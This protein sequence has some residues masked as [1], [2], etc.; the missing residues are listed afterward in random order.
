[1]NDDE[2]TARLGEIRK[3]R[4]DLL[5]RKVD[6]QN[7]GIAE[8]EDE[9]RKLG[10][11]EGEI[12]LALFERSVR[13]FERQPWVKKETALERTKEQA[14]AYRDMFNG[15]Y[16][17]VLEARNERLEVTHSEWPK[18]PPI[19][20]FGVD[21]LRAPL[22]DAYSA[23]I[24]GALSTRLDLMDARGQV[25]DAWRQIAVT[26][27]A[28]QGVLNVGYNYSVTGT[29]AKYLGYSPATAQNQLVVN[30]QLP[31]VRRAQRNA[32]RSALINYQ[33]TRRLLMAF[34]DNIANDVRND[35]RQ[36]RALA[37]V[38][39]IQQRVVEQS[40]SIV[41][42]AAE[43]LFAPPVPG[44]VLDPG[45]AASLTNQLLTA[46]SNLLTA[47]NTLYVYW[48]GFIQNRIQLYLDLELMQLDE[49]GIW[50]DEQF[51]GLED[52]PAGPDGRPAGERLPAPL[53]VVP[54]G[55]AALGEPGPGGRR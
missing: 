10:Q 55:P 32:Y 26:A 21:A 25:V 8:P 13:A 27:N 50:R 52:A 2:I 38:Y 47:Q 6:R 36:L 16:Q 3:Q 41:E 22:D 18:L 30:A 7:K 11:L 40:Y 28:L 14:S 9:V 44:T 39:K 53:P 5:D 31:L 46:L 37:E 45:T 1:L 43:V 35:I 20:V 33:S 17:L 12:D 51:P 42:N 34:E 15:F 54:V 24:Q 29:N 48:V 49:R 23:C 4:S 19:P